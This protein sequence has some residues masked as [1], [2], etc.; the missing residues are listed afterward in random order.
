VA[1]SLTT[2][3]VRAQASAGPGAGLG[4]RAA[5]PRRRPASG[6]ARVPHHTAA[7]AAGDG[8]V[9]PCDH[10]VGCVR[11]RTHPRWAAVQATVPTSCTRRTICCCC[12]RVSPATAAG[13]P[14][15]LVR[16]HG[17][18]MRG[19]RAV[20][21]EERRA[22]LGL[23][24]WRR[25]GPPRL[26]SVALAVLAAMRLG[27]TAFVVP[28]PVPRRAA[29]QLAVPRPGAHSTMWRGFSMQGPER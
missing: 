20:L 13:W 25:R 11:E 28:A 1:V 16:A 4:R 2:A 7:A 26:R 23:R 9:Y 19:A 12:S 22:M 15:L 18:K 10:G 6:T 27:G 8:S 24:P 17:A 14:P 21:N 5:G 29:D 3:A